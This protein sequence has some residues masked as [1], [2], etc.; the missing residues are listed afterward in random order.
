[1]EK[2]RGTKILAIVAICIAVLGMTIGFASF[3]TVLNINGTGAVKGSN[4]EVIFDNLSAATLVGTAVEKTHPTIQEDSTIIETYDVE[5][6]TPGDSVSYTFDI[7]NNGTYD[8]EI[9]GIS[10]AGIASKVLTATG[11]DE[12]DRANV[13]GKLSYTLKY[14]G[15]AKDGQDL[16]I[17]DTIAKKVDTTPGKVTAKLTLS[18]ADFED[19]SLLPKDTVTIGNLDVAITYRQKTAASA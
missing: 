4:W 11:G 15:G 12:D 5:L 1:M 8:A 13:L 9:S 18:Y 2:D 19:E 14:V 10:M 7:L 17:G 16:A 6:V 3:S